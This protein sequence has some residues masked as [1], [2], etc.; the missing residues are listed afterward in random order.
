M[1]KSGHY[2]HTAVAALV[3]SLSAAPAIAQMPTSIP[4]KMKTNVLFIYDSSN[5]M[6]GQLDGKPKYE[7]AQSI[8]EDVIKGLPQ[9]ASLGLIAY[10]HRR[11]NDCSDLEVLAPIG[12]QSAAGIKFITS[13]MKPIGITPLSE[14]LREGANILKNTSGAKMIV[15]ITDGGEECHGDPCA[16]AR[17]LAQ[18]GMVIRVN[19]VGLSP[20]APERLQLQCIAKEGAGRFFDV[21]DKQALYKT[22]NSLKEDIAQYQPP[23]KPPEP[24]PNPEPPPEPKPEPKIDDTNLI[25]VSAGGQIELAGLTRWDNSISGKDTDF[26]WTIPGQEV[27]FS[28]KD[29]KTTAF[30]RFEIAIPETL[31]QN[32]KEFELLAASYSPGGPFK[33]IGRFTTVNARQD[34]L[35]QSFTFNRVKARYLK[36]KVLSNYGH[37]MEGYGSTQVFQLRVK[38]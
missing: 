23:G 16:V 11:K 21:K 18:S 32:V 31:S 9:D 2:L 19:T 1:V 30:S 8:L 37:T 4:V 38:P 29:R 7:S 25:G 6:W 22:I 15:L 35:Y 34:S 26:I 3:L 20:N 10:G 17:E 13:H 12:N 33:S 27:I 36:F 24:E 14:A 5:S 28:F